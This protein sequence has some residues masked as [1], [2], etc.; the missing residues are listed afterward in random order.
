[1]LIPIGVSRQV[2][3]G[4]QGENMSSSKNREEK[5]LTGQMSLLT[6][7]TLALVRPRFA[8]IFRPAWTTVRLC[9]RG[10]RRKRRRKRRRG[11]IKKGGRRGERE[12]EMT[13][14]TL[15]KAVGEKCI[16]R[17][18]DSQVERE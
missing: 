9:F 4:I 12:E 16:S 17:E 1:M 13:T 3:R 5:K 10:R 8:R 18:N 6:P 11:R 7:V 2:S 14:T 15:N